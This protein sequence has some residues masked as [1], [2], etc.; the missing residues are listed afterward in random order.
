[1]CSLMLA[2]GWLW[3]LGPKSQSLAEPVMPVGSI[4]SSHWTDKGLLGPSLEVFSR[5]FLPAWGSYYGDAIK[6]KC[7][8]GEKP[9]QEME[10]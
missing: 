7:F 1:M 3:F 4:L 8:A 6:S 5:T 2:W 9:I 10:P